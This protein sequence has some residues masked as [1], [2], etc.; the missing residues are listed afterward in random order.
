[1]SWD[2]VDTLA[3]WRSSGLDISSYDLDHTTARPWRRPLWRPLV[4]LVRH[5][6]MARF[7][8]GHGAGPFGDRVPPPA[9]G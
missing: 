2:L 7:Y 5:A 9:G 6:V 4:T 1:M 8:G 3:G